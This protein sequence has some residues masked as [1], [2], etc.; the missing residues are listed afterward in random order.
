MRAD[1]YPGKLKCHLS[2]EEYIDKKVEDWV[3]YFGD[4]QEYQNSCL[5]LKVKYLLP[6]LEMFNVNKE[7]SQQ[8]L[9]QSSWLRLRSR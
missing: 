1:P 8:K 5:S 2:K 4:S 7:R 9:Q 6:H 3:G